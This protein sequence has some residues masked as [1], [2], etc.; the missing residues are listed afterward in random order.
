MAMVGFGYFATVP[1]ALDRDEWKLWE[2]E[3][4]IQSAH[5]PVRPGLEEWVPF[6]HAC[7]FPPVAADGKDKNS[8]F[9]K[10]RSQN[11]PLSRFLGMGLLILHR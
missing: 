10:S 1:L 11:M 3:A 2:P 6:A 9:E 5:L 4:P 8:P 7:P